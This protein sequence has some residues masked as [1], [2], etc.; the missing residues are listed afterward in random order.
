MLSSARD[1][2]PHQN[3]ELPALCKLKQAACQGGGVLL[4]WR[5]GCP[6]LHSADSVFWGGSAGGGTAVV[7]IVM[8]DQAGG[9]WLLH[10]DLGA[11]GVPCLVTL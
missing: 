10:S 11:C 7:Q 1:S 3:T 8:H 6:I 5:D 2:A 4:P 9:G